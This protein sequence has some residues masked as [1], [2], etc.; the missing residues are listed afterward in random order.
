VGASFARSVPAH[1]HGEQHVG[2]GAIYEG[3]GLVEEMACDGR[4]QSVSPEDDVDAVAVLAFARL[5]QPAGEYPLLLETSWQYQPMEPPSHEHPRP[6]VPDTAEAQL[7]LVRTRTSDVPVNGPVN[8]A[9]KPVLSLRSF[10]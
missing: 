7:R 4:Q 6:E 10:S 9:V 3:H 1:R 8:G 5:L 2:V